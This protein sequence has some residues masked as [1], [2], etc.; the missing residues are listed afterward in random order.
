MVLYI[1]LVLDSLLLQP[2]RCFFGLL[3][4]FCW[5]PPKVATLP[6]SRFTLKELVAWAHARIHSL[7]RT[8]YGQG[9]DSAKFLGMLA[10]AT[11]DDADWQNVMALVQPDG[12]IKRNLRAQYPDESVPFSGD[13]LAGFL[14]A[15]VQRLPSLSLADRITLA[16]LWQRTTW[17]GF[18]LLF[19][20]A[21]TG[22]KTVFGRGHVWRP[23]WVL[24]SEEVLTAIAWLYCG[25]KITGATRYRVACFAFIIMQFPSL[26]LGCPDGQLWLGRLY[27]IA[28]Y[29]THSKV[30]VFYA[31]WL[32]TGG[33]HFM[34]ALAQ[35]YKRHAA[36]NAD[37]AILA[38][39]A[40][41]APGWRETALN[42]ISCAVEKGRYPCPQDT[43]YL[44]IIWPPEMVM[45]SGIIP[46]PEFRGG[47]YIWERNPVKG[48]VLDDDY[49]AKKGLDVIFPA[50]M[51]TRVDRP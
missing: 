40:V 42:L 41:D 49:R 26:L 7:D 29:N 24:G 9:G 16:K 48:N 33:Y 31:G 20:D 17:Y 45:R 23:W 38:G 25:W 18:P 28:T 4:R 19:A 12:T 30:L 14:L 10:T 8:V 36:Y 11:G 44:S 5:H 13:M 2:F 22:K 1:L 6:P 39:S 3:L 21:A 46:P 37:I 34:E 15:V 27:A 51:L 47:D 43:K 32:M 50:L 35:S